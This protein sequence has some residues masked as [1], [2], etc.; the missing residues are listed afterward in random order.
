MALENAAVRPQSTVADVVAVLFFPLTLGAA[1]GLGYYWLQAGWSASAILG[2]SAVIVNLIIAVAERVWPYRPDWN[3][4]QGDILTDIAHNFITSFGLRELAKL[5]LL[6]VLVPVSIYLA[7]AAGG[8]LWPH[9]LP[10]WAQC[11]LAIVLAD[12]GGYWM[13]RLCHEREYFWR[14]H[15]VHH[16]PGRLYWLNA[17]R[18]HPLGMALDYAARALL[19]VALGA[20]AEVLVIY[21]VFEST[22][23]VTQHAN[24]RHTLG[25]LNWVFSGAEL[26]RW[27]H[28]KVLGEAN[29][30]YGKLV[31]WD[32]VFGTYYL[33]RDRTGPEA[34]GLADMPVFPQRFFSQ[35]LVPWRWRT[36]KAEQP[37][38]GKTL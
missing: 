19:P 16:C 1:L 33:P 28:S 34:I 31:L 5:G 4:A 14:F 13:H 23:G 18:D 32:L 22:L 35:L 29:N 17:G 6:M 21:Y 36:L 7:G 37:A 12:F 27:H 2:S 20:P 24:V 8:S 26:H 11:V 10:F 25:P 30:N 3:R 38:A 9:A 15:S